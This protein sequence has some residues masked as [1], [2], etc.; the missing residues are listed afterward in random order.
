MENRL[1]DT[2]RKCRYIWNKERKDVKFGQ[3][4]LSHRELLS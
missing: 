4:Y 3:M 1:L 2:V